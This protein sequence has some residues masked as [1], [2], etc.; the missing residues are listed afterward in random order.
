MCRSKM[1]GA[2]R[3]VAADARRELQENQSH[4]P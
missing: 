3:T 2:V 1:I 4:D